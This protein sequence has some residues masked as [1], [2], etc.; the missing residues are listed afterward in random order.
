MTARPA[1]AIGSATT[2]SIAVSWPRFASSVGRRPPARS[3]CLV[4]R[5]LR[6]S[7]YSFRA[8]TRHAGLLDRPGGK[9]A[10]QLSLG[11]PPDDHRYDECQGGKRRQLCPELPAGSL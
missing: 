9:S 8:T 5:T 3:G 11:K 10:D 2:V 4:S 1:S 6:R 7:A